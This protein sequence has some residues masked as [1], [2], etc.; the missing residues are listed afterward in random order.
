M[1]Q[2]GSL[3]LLLLVRGRERRVKV[4]QSEVFTLKYVRLETTFGQT[5]MPAEGKDEP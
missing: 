5:T 4:E 2:R 3:G 1:Y